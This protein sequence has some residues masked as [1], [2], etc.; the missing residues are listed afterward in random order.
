MSSKAAQS[1]IA[2]AFENIVTLE[3]HLIDGGFGSWLAESLMAT[4]STTRVQPVG[5]SPVVCGTVGSQATLN[6]F[7]GLDDV[8]S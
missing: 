2:A 3:D 4:D 6:R 8:Q 5:L 1:K 7:G